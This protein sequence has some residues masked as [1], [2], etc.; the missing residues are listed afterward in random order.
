MKNDNDENSVN[1]QTV[2]KKFA[3]FPREYWHAITQS[4][5]DDMDANYSRQKPSG[6]DLVYFGRDK[7]T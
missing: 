6:S 1:Q 4:F 2:V 3:K 5:V 7:G